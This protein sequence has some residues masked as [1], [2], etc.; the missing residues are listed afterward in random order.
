MQF[1]SYFIS[2]HLYLCHILL[3]WCFDWKGE[4]SRNT[5]KKHWNTPLENLRSI[6]DLW[7]WEARDGL[8]NNGSEQSDEDYNHRGK[9]QYL[10]QQISISTSIVFMYWLQYNGD[11]YSASYDYITSLREGRKGSKVEKTGQKNELGLGNPSCRYFLGDLVQVSP[12]IPKG[13]I[14]QAG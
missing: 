13:Q 10:I 5:K 12:I 3:C 14:S 11:T 1:I 7:Q 2:R 6:R 4:T 8:G 9:T